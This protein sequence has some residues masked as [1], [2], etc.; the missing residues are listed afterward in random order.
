[1]GVDKYEIV[2][3]KKKKKKILKVLPQFQSN[4]AIPE[5]CPKH[6]NV[7]EMKNWNL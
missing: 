1:M 7:K 2:I 5:Q 3:I 4:K 6:G